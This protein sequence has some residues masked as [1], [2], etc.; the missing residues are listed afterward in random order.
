MMT[1]LIHT[2]RTSV[3]DFLTLLT[4]WINKG[5]QTRP[6]GNIWITVGQV[7]FLNEAMGIE[8]CLS[9]KKYSIIRKSTMYMSSGGSTAIQNMH[10]SHKGNMEK[11]VQLY[12][13]QGAS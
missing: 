3:N 7:E 1:S 10:C 11:V 5:W 6:F 9:R 8:M 2:H 13:N 4:V 12:K